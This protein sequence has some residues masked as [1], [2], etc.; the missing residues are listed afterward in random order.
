VTVRAH[1]PSRVASALPS[2]P[3]D[4]WRVLAELPA[5]RVLATSRTT[6]TALVEPPGVGRIV[7][8]RWTWPTR[9]DRLKGALRTTWA[10]RSPARREFEALTRLR[11]LPG[12][13][14]APEPLGFL[15]RRERGVLVACLLV[16]EEIVG[17]TDLAT[18][19]AGSSPDRARTRLLE[20]LAR[21]VRAM[22]DAGLVD[23]DCHPRNVLV[24]PDGRV[25]KVD[26]PKQRRRTGPASRADRARDLAAL[27]V[28][29]ARLATSAERATFFDA[30]GA[31]ARL[32]TGTDAFRKRIDARE[33]RRLP[34]A[35]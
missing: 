16:E 1:L 18:H 19:L 17:A 30:Y 21:R 14:F 4:A 34:R 25:F 5:V 7:R 33:S 13:P 6:Q 22:H 8:K 20:L 23:F 10:A 15:E 11:A 12:G 24:A 35:E 29:L 26:C 32:R 9:R 31:E 27:D 28:G 3:V 2:G